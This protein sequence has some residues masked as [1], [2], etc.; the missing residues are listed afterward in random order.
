MTNAWKSPVAGAALIILL[1]V[2]AYLPALRSGFIWDDDDYVT[3]NLALRS[4]RGLEGIWFRP[5]STVQYYP[6]D[7]TSHWIEYHL[8]GLRPLGY[9]VTNVLLHAL[10]AVL[11][12]LA[13]KRLKIPWSW[14]VAT[15]FA[16]HPVNVESVAWITERKNVLS[17]LFYLLALHAYLRFR[18]LDAGEETPVCNWWYYLLTFLFFLCALLGKTST[19]SLPA[20]LALLIWWKKGRVTRRDVTPLVPLFILGTVMG[21]MTQ[22]MEQRAGAS[23]VEWSLSAAQRCL[24]A[25]RALWFYAGKLFWPRPIMFIYPRWQVDAAVAWQY[26]FPL[27]ALAVL[28]TLW[29]LRFRIGRGPLVAVLFFAGTLVPALGFFNVFYFRY[30]YVAD[31]FQY[32]AQLGLLCLAG[33]VFSVICKRVNREGRILATLTSALVLLSLGV[34]AWNR[35]HVYQN[36]ETLWRDTLTKNPRCWMAYN[37]LGLTQRHAG[38]VQDAIASYRQSLQINPD[39]AE[40]HYNL[41]NSLL[42]IGKVNDAIAEYEQALR[43]QPDSASAQNGLAMALVRAGRIQDAIARYQRSLQTNPNPAEAHY[44]FGN[45]LLQAGRV[46]DA[47]AEYEQVVRLRPDSA[48]AQNNL[49]VALARS[50]RIQDAMAHYQQALHINPKDADAQYNFGNAFQQLGNVPEAISHYRAAVRIDPNHAEAHSNLGNLLLQEG[51]VNDAIVE[52]ERAMQIRPDFAAAESN[53]GLALARLGKVQDAITHYQ[54]ALRIDPNRAEAHYNLGNALQQLGNVPEAIMHYQEALLIDPND[55]D[56]HDKLGLALMS[57]GKSQEAIDQLRQALRI[58]PDLAE[59]Q[60]NLAWLLVS[61]GQDS[62]SFRPKQ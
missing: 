48:K 42:D 20:V 53:L 58:K 16:L 56:A 22:R 32:V 9:H 28:A 62:N 40:A 23:G 51:R 36:A 31:H 41:G 30:S 39:N 15:V 43:I 3:R 8:W 44:N 47:V 35:A 60:K 21:L 13:L 45:F 5:G 4:L 18:S 14:W 49:G 52:Y 29:L 2:I 55:A 46:D 10:N 26:L 24:V 50:G 6:L 59:A 38:K 25:G 34:S 61:L 37:N 33:S 11:L 27:A 17:G 12:W 54:Q 57:I 19:C 1:T 7:F